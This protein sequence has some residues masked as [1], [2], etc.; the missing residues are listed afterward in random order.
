MPLLSEIEVEATRKTKFETVPKGNYVLQLTPTSA[1]DERG[2]LQLGIQI[3]DGPFKGRRIFQDLPQ[4]KSVSDW[5]N[6][7]LKR[8]AEAVGADVLP[9]ENPVEFLNRVAANGHSRFTADLYVE[10]YPKRDGSGTAEKTKINTRSF[11]VA[12]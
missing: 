11:G 2:K 4:A 5:P 10:T 7:V 9:G 1:F 6:Q 3:A 12:A 8:I